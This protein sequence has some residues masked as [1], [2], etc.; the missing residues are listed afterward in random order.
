MSHK[1]QRPIEE[2]VAEAATAALAQQHYVSPIDVFMRMGWLPPAHVED[3]RKGREPYLEAVI[4]GNLSKISSVMASLRHWARDRNLKPS[5]TAYLVRT[6]GPR[7]DL[8][9]SKSGDPDIERAYRTHY[10]S[11]ELSER[12]QENLREKL[13][14]PPELV[15]FD[16]V[17]DSKC[18]ECEAELAKGSLLVMEAD[19]PL[20][21][22][23]ADLGSTWFTYPAAT[24]R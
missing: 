5:E 20:C 12:K 4:Q 16:I 24:Q 15:V 10:V 9:F 11:P 1:H 14:K 2:R 7:R 6:V 8:Q 3:W 19:R 23:C 17:R 22:E 13:S 18:S 21:L